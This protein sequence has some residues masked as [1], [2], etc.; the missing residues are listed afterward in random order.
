MQKSFKDVPET[1]SE[2]RNIRLTKETP[3]LFIPILEHISRL[4]SCCRYLNLSLLIGNGMELK[5]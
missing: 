3:P 4:L 1:I 2:M 5:K